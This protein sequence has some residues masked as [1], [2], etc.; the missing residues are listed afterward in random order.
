MP[1][2]Q[3]WTMMIFFLQIFCKIFQANQK[4]LKNTSNNRRQIGISLNKKYL[5]EWVKEQ[6]AYT[7]IRIHFGRLS[8]LYGVAECH[9]IV[10]ICFYFCSSCA[11]NYDCMFSPLE[12]DPVRVCYLFSYTKLRQCFMKV[13]MTAN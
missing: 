8:S 3:L 12:P 2:T 5:Y 11:R 1:D 4:V 9:F 13:P 7:K 6:T 10:L